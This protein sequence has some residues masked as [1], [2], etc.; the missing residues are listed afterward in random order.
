MTTTTLT[1]PGG[2]AAKFDELLARRTYLGL[3]EGRPDQELNAQELA[4]LQE[5]A[6]G[7]WGDRARALVPPREDARGAL[8][9]WLCAA[10]LTC[11]EPRG[12]GDPDMMGSE[13]VL[14]WAQ[15]EPPRVGEIPQEIIAAVDW[16]TQASNF[17]Y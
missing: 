9:K 15:D 12:Q 13:L 14:L 1:F 2:V 6:T 16:A 10:W 8:P 11:T 7:L 5:A 17:D 4:G 3:I